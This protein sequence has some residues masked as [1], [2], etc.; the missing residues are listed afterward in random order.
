MRGC[1]TTKDS[2]ATLSATDLTANASQRYRLSWGILLCILILSVLTYL[3]LLRL[4]FISDDFV[5]IPLSGQYF[6]HGWLTLFTDPNLRTRATY[7]G[8]NS[9]FYHAFGF[10]PAPFYALSIL[11]HFACTLC[12]YLLS[13]SLR[14]DNFTALAAACFFA[15]YEGHNEAVMWIAASSDLLVCLFI[16]LCAICWLKWLDGNSWPWYAGCVGA[17]MGA[18][19]SKESFFVAPILLLLLPQIEPRVSNRR[20][21]LGIAPIALLSGLYVFWNFI[22]RVFRPGYSDI[23]F[24]LHAPWLWVLALSVWGLLYVWGTVSLTILL[25][26]RR[27]KD[28]HMIGCWL[29]WIV[30]CLFPNCFLSYMNRVPSRH[31]YLASVGLAMLVGVAANRLS[32][33]RKPKLLILFA[34]L[35]LLINIEIIWVKKTSQFRERAEPSEL[36]RQAAKQSAGPVEIDCTNLEQIVAAAAVE[37]RGKQATFP[38]GIMQSTQHCFVISYRDQSGELV[39][40]NKYVETDKHGTFY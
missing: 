24:S 19:A 40:V 10:T 5:Q 14:T 7:M 18:A 3:P 32:K 11:L 9:W 8:L 28:G 35:A 23:R 20:V 1:Y 33:S 37:S 31:T 21:F 13:A 38:N 17:L 4:P 22:D 30:V 2:V 27:R 25:F 26:W 39:K 16:L 15:V 34:T 6:S 36:L 12:I 29:L